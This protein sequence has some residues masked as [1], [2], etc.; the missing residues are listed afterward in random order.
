M[1]PANEP[2][3]GTSD[4]WEPEVTDWVLLEQAARDVFGRYGYGELRTPIF[5]RTDV[6]V[7]SIGDDTEVVQKE[8]YT[9]EDR[10]GR[11]LTLRPEGTAGAMRAIACHGLADGEQ[12]RVFYMGPMFRGERPA[13]GRRRQFHQVG[14]EA[15]GGL[16]PYQDAEAIAM[17]VHYLE[18]IGVSGGRVRLNSRG[19]PEDR[20][21]VSAAMRQHFAPRAQDMC[22]DCQRRLDSNVWRILD[23][24]NAACQAAV[25]GAPKMVDLLGDESRGF[26]AAV[27]R[28][29]DQLGVAYELAPRLVRGLDYYVHTV[30]EV[31]HSGLG[32][33]DALAGGGRYRIGLPGVKRPLDGVGFAAGMER[34]LMARESLGL[35]AAGR[36]GADVF[37][38][39]LGDEAIP[40]GLGLAQALR[41]TDLGLRVLAGLGGRSLKAQ[42]R[43]AHREGARWALILGDNELAAGTIVCKTM[44]TSQ[45]ETIR[46]DDLVDWLRQAAAAPAAAASTP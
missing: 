3:P 30:F 32:A 34:L 7:R 14:V 26:F 11:S 29:L 39:A 20:A 8:M 22:P 42:M 18:A 4:L 15:V 25:E 40:A 35:K 9:F 27:C 33:Q 44:A 10:G 37:I 45:Q 43:A 1:A 28:G 2:L 21:A 41:R 19:L 17:L 38:V 16:E 23:C 24:K 31:V 13:A 46:R 36:P 5:E 12:L 6:F